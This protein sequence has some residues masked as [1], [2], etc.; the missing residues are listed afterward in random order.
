MEKHN[1]YICK[2]SSATPTFDTW[3]EVIR[4]ASEKV[5]D[6]YHGEV[7]ITYAFDPDAVTDVYFLDGWSNDQYCMWVRK[8]CTKNFIPIRYDREE[9]Q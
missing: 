9:L 4:K 8:M 1:V 2:P 3:K 6:L 7:H 5:C